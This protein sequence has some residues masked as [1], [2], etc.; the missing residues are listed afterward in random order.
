MERAER[1][2]PAIN[3]IPTSLHPGPFTLLGVRSHTTY[4]GHNHPIFSRLPYAVKRG[5]A[6]GGRTL[7]GSY[8]YTLLASYTLGSYIGLNPEAVDGRLA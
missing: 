6:A 3:P 5:R 7:L 1:E 4:R 8:T 2:I